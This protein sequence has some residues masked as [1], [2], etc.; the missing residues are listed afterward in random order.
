MHEDYCLPEVLGE[1]GRPV[2]PGEKGELV[3]TSL[4]RKAMPLLRY[5]TRDIVQL[6]DR[7]CPCGRTLV[8]FAGGVLARLD[9]MKKVRGIIVYPRRIEEIVRVHTAVD[10]FQVVFR[11]VDG[12][13]DILV[14]VDPAAGASKEECARMERALAEE[15]RVGLGI[16]VSVEVTECGALPRWDHKA[17]RVHDERTEV[18]F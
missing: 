8:A 5:R 13:D 1:A 3:F 10:E 16:R 2:T 15:L 14:R 9:D 11:R 18:P 12:L 7:R 6:A 17:R 4:Y